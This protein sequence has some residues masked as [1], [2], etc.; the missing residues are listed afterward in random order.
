M[1][2]NKEGGRGPIS[3]EGC[4]DSVIKVFVN[5]SRSTSNCDEDFT[6]QIN[7][8]FINQKWFKRV[9]NVNFYYPMK[10][11]ESDIVIVNKEKICHWMY[12]TTK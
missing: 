4:I 1:S 9:E 8:T 7:W 2:I 11:T 10:I 12:M 6:V 3:N 5:Y